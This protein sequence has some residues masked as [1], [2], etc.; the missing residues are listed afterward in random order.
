MERGISEIKINKLFFFFVNINNKLALV[1]FKQKKKEL[2]GS[3]RDDGV[4]HAIQRMRQLSGSQ[5]TH[6]IDVC[7]LCSCGCHK[8]CLLLQ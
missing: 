8:R 4:R 6:W 7:P 1:F 3:W 2:T 5:S